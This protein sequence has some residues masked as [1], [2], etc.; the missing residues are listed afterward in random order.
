MPVLLMDNHEAWKYGTRH[1]KDCPR[2]NGV[3]VQQRRLGAVE[4]CRCEAKARWDVEG[5]FVATD[6]EEWKEG[7]RPRSWDPVAWDF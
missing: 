3:P 7:L 6:A 2:G 5:C 4:R 1:A